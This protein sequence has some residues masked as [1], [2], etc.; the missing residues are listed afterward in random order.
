MLEDIEIGILNE[1]ECFVCFDTLHNKFINLNCCKK[2]NIH[3]QCLFHIFLNYLS[4]QS[5][6]I[7]CPLCRQEIAIKD[8]FNVDELIE[9]FSYLDDK[10]KCKFFAKFNN[11]ISYNYIESNQVN[12]LDET[13][14][15]ITNIKFMLSKNLPTFMLIVL[16]I[17]AIVI[18]YD[19]NN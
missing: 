17:I 16:I 4:L 12:Q 8:Y 11:I 15:S 13:T 14:S 10:T 19:M 1:S 5:D 7:A 18:I 3:S 9:S 2:Q 6:K